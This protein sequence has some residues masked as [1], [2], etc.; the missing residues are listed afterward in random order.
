MG[1]IY[2][3]MNTINNKIYIGKTTRTL[4]ERF[5]EHIK[6]AESHE[7]RYL[8]NAMNYY[9]YDA[10]I[11][12]EI[13]E[14]DDEALN[15]LESYYISLFRSNNNK[16]GYNMTS[17]G[18]GVPKLSSEVEAIRA[19]K[20][21]TALKGRHQPPELVEQRAKK[22]RG[23]KRSI[24]V[25][26]RMSEAHKGKTPWNKGISPTEETKQKLRE[27]NLGKKQSDATKLKRSEKISKL[28]WYNNGVRNIRATERPEGFVSGRINFKPS[29]E[30]KA[31]SC[32][33]G[34][35]WYTN[36]VTNVM[37]YE[38]PKGFWLGKTKRMKE[39]N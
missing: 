22:L 14:A 26:L 15:E 36:G 23:K 11:I 10:F 29:A 7:N 32:H 28:M 30:A 35:H 1:Y 37:R 8:Y 31:R 12:E 25:R 17:G 9:G 18:D 39:E 6:N 13:I 38:C 3:I 34:T 20:I 33:K 19:A 2:K 16:F 21:S 24:E 4:Q 5:A 27:A